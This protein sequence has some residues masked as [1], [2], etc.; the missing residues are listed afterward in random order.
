MSKIDID[1]GKRWSNEIAEQLK[2]T[3]FGII[4]LTPTNLSEP[5]LMFEAGALA[6]TMDDNTFV[7]P[8]LIGLEPSDIPAGPLDQ[9]KAKR[10]TKN[11]TLELLKSINSAMGESSLEE[12]RLQRLFER[13][14]PDLE[15]KLGELPPEET[16]LERRD[17][18]DMVEEILESVRDFSRVQ[19]EDYKQIAR[20]LLVLA[21]YINKPPEPVTPKPSNVNALRGLAGLGTFTT[22]PT[23]FSLS[24]LPTL[25]G[26]DI[27]DDDKGEGT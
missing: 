6:K 11:E 1:A 17:T 15:T 3:K 20:L 16:T 27:S 21:N 9:F 7:C 8:Y 12:D 23:G 10:A 18:Q 26:G 13:G 4:C 19:S 5:W 2:A 14:W 24:A 22:A 25:L